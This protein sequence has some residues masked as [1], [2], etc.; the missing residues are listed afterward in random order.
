MRVNTQLGMN[1]TFVITDYS[2]YNL[3][4]VC[5]NSGFYYIGVLAGTC[6]N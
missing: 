3:I 5:F 4:F 6:S 2:F 1:S